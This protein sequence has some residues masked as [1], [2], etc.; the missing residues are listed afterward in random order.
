MNSTLLTEL[1]DN[2]GMAVMDWEE[3][4]ELGYHEIGRERAIRDAAALILERL[5]Y[6]Q[7]LTE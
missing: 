2:I 6:E 1:M 7:S 4:N 3:E 5:G